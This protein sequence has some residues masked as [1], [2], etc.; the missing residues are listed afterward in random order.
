MNKHIHSIIY[1][2]TAAFV[3]LGLYS[4][5]EMNKDQL[6]GVFLIIN[7]IWFAA[8]SYKSLDK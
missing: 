2:L 5:F 4:V 3:L 6:L 8:R 7:G 1:H